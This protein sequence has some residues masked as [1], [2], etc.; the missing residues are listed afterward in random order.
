MDANLIIIDN[1]N[2]YIKDIDRQL[3]EMESWGLSWKNSSFYND[4]L[5]QKASWIKRKNEAS[6]SIRD[7]LL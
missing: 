6:K 1:A 2:A 4:L 3:K 5:S 7:N